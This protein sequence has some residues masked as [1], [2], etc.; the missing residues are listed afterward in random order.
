MSDTPANSL[1]FAPDEFERLY[2]SLE[3]F[4]TPQSLDEVYSILIEEAKRLSGAA[5]GSLFIYQKSS[6]IKV[7]TTLPK[8]MAIIPRKRG[9][10]FRSFT[11]GIPLLLTHEQLKK[12]HPEIHPKLRLSLSIPLT[13]AKQSIGLIGLI[14]DKDEK[15]TKHEIHKLQ[16]FGAIASLILRKAQLHQEAL[17]ALQTRDL[18]LSLASHEL[19]TPLTTLHGY[20]HMIQKKVQKK[21]LPPPQWVDTALN[22]TERLK[23]LVNELL[24]LNQV[25]TGKLLYNREQ[26]PFRIIVEKAIANFQV[27]HPKRNITY[28]NDLQQKSD[29]IIGDPDKLLEVIQNILENAEKFSPKH[30]PIKLTLRYQYPYLILTIKDYGEGIQKDELPHLFNEFYKANDYKKGMGLGLYIAKRVLHRHSGDIKIS[31]TV[32]KGTTVRIYLP[33]MIDAKRD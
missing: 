30:T 23:S 8:N 4:L 10:L 26:I 27:I 2:D 31:S 22:E 28:K 6:L 17:D 29:T 25:K 13:Y 15:L 19:R 20:L 16:Y 7:L 24:G 9:N 18:F 3:R 32:G 11:R 14:W 1:T 5:F 12:S 33:R 21:H